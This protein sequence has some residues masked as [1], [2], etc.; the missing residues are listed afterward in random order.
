MAFSPRKEAADALYAILYGG[1][2]ASIHIDKRLREA[3]EIPDRDRRF[4]TGLIYSTLEH[5][6][7]LDRALDSFS[8]VPTDRM[9]PYL[10]V[11]LRMAL[12]QILYMDRIPESAAIHECVELVKRSSVSRLAGFANGVLR[13]AQRASY[14][15]ELP[16]PEKEPAAHLSVRYDVPEPLVRLWL[17]SYGRET[18]ELL[19]R[20]SQGEKPLSVRANTLKITADALAEKLAALQEAPLRRGLPETAVFYP[21]HGGS[22]ADWDLYREGFLYAQDESSVIAAMA[23]A[24]R[25]GERILDLCA[26]PGG[27]SMVLAQLMG[28]QGEIDSRDLHP[29]RAELIR[30]NA[31]R[32][33]IRSVRA[34]AADGCD[35]AAVEEGAYDRVLLDAPCSGYGVLRGKPDIKY[36]RSLG[37]EGELVA[38]QRKLLETAARALRPGGRL[39][40]S[41]CTL[42]PAENEKQVEAFLAG[43][44]AFRLLDAEKDLPFLSECDKIAGGYVTLLP[45][46]GGRDGF[47]LAVMEKARG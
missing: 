18:A 13:G 12:A 14:R 7:S 20:R 11:N 43:H 15:F 4:Y 39:V 45:Q 40:Y 38:L 42:D 16:D 21:E 23:L 35:P 5:L 37:E 2:Y 3:G 19:L 6:P 32:L 9:K 29:H 31:E 25:A 8:S 10:A 28:D 22:F 36:H 1:A 41:T 26:A 24:P 46:E 27:K 44:P 33:G 30:K 17:S 34:K 47:F